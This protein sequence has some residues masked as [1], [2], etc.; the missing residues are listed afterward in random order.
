MDAVVHG[1]GAKAGEEPLGEFVARQADIH[2][3]R[4]GAFVEP[5]EM[6]VEERDAAFD[7][8]QSFPDAVAEHEAGI[9]DRDDRLFARQQRAVDRDENS[10]VARIVGVIVR[11]G[12]HGFVSLKPSSSLPG[13]TGNPLSYGRERGSAA[14]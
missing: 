13:N 12:A 14:E 3:D 5:V 8:A 2:V 6:R 10:G 11:S 7:Q 9:E 1:V 4:L